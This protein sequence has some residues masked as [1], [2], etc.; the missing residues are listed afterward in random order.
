ME[1]KIE[2]F[3][4]LWG[5]DQNKRNRE[6]KRQRRLIFSFSRQ[7][8][9][10]AGQRWT[11]LSRQQQALLIIDN[12]QHF[13][14]IIPLD[15]YSH[16]HIYGRS[17][18]IAQLRIYISPVSDNDSKMTS[19]LLK[20]NG[21]LTFVLDSWRKSLSKNDHLPKWK[22]CPLDGPWKINIKPVA[23]IIVLILIVHSYI[24]ESSE[25][26]LWRTGMG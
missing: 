5:L 9:A 23:T 11:A 8:S 14:E 1:C 24:L 26:N 2:H 17:V 22:S 19:G 10:Q 13:C 7:L 25:L 16:A 21:C 6:M 20:T 4:F 18:G 3:H 12:F 15:A